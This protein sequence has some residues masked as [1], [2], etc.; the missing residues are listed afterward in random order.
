[1]YPWLPLY[2]STYQFSKPTIPPRIGNNKII[3]QNEIDSI[4]CK[5]IYK[6]I[7]EEIEVQEAITSTHLELNILVQKYR[8]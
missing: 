4:V 7:D 2:H 5:W 3:P 6:L 1:L 8:K